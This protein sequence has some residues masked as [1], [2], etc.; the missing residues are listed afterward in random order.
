L[1][2]YRGKGCEACGGTGYKGRVGIHEMLEVTPEIEELI[3]ARKSSTDINR[4]AEKQGMMHLFDDG[5]EKMLKGVTSLDELFRVAQPPEC[6]PSP[7]LQR[8]KP[9]R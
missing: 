1:L 4:A 2:L 8:G 3:I 6:G 7:I 5:F 9:K